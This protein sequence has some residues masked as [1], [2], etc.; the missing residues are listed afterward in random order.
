MKINTLLL[1][2]SCSPFFLNYTNTFFFFSQFT[3]FHSWSV[4]LLLSLL[5][6]FPFSPWKPCLNVFQGQNICFQKS[7]SVG[8]SRPFPNV[9]PPPH[10]KGC[11]LLLLCYRLLLSP[12]LSH[13]DNHHLLFKFSEV[14]KEFSDHVGGF[15]W[16]PFCPS[17]YV[18]SSSTIFS[19]RAGSCKCILSFPLFSWDANGKCVIWP[20]F[21]ICPAF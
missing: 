11:V 2:F 1:N 10:P 5:L 19:R 18:E 9:L 7:I 17:G 12:Q 4:P 8:C 13:H 20:Q 6:C 14:R 3:F 16:S 15:S 21:L